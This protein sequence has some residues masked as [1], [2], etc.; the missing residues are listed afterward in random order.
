MDPFPIWYLGQDWEFD[1][2]GSWSLQFH[3]LSVKPVSRNSHKEYKRNY[4][5]F[6]ATDANFCI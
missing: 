5:Y 3:L 6:S 4:T 1:C 2:I